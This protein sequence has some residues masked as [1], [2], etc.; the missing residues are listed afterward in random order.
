VG[1]I[2]KGVW[3]LY[4]LFLVPTVYEILTYMRN[5]FHRVPNKVF[6]ED[7]KVIFQIASRGFN[8]SALSSNVENVFHWAG[9]Y[10]KDYEVWLAIEESARSDFFEELARKYGDRLRILYVLKEYTTKRETLYKARALSYALE[11]RIKEGLVGENTWVFLMDEESVIGEDTII[12]IVDFTGKA[13]IQ[14][15]SSAKDLSCTQIN[16]EKQL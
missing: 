3:L 6:L 4:L 11:T 5:E 14:E 2:L 15:S 12:G 13:R 1:N 8:Q 10:I 16:G 9:K 7:A